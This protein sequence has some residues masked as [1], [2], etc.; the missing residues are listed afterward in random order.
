M[1]RLVKTPSFVA[2]ASGE[3][4]LGYPPQSAIDTFIEEMFEFVK[5]E[6][7][8]DILFRT[9]RYTRFQLRRLQ[10]TFQLESGKGGK[11]TGVAVCH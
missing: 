11:Y 6:T 9:L 4:L 1:K 3:V 7:N 10:E 2:I 8:I 5:T